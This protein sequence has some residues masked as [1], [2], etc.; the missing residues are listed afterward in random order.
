MKIVKT[1]H[2]LAV[3]LPREIVELLGLKEGQEL[4]FKHISGKVFALFP[5]ETGKKPSEKKGK[6]LTEEELKVLKKLNKI[7]FTERTPKKVKDVLTKEEW[8]VLKEL[9]KK[10][11]ILKMVHGKYEK[12]GGVYSI[13]REYYGMLKGVEKKKEK[14]EVDALVDVLKRDGFFSTKDQKIAE[15]LAERLNTELELGEVAAVKSFDKT[16]YFVTNQALAS[17]G[18]QIR[19]V[20]K[21][22]PLTAEEIATKLKKDPTLVKAVLEIL[23]ESGEVI[24]KRKNV[25]SLA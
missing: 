20:L 5:K 19:K 16:F 15:E 17:V 3:V 1:R 13:S 6:G 14:D 11:V 24:E 25:Y 7:R 8:E 21:S 4:E 12:S 23:R 10:R 18:D 9:L 22:G 2:G